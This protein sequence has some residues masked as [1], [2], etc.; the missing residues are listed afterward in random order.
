VNLTTRPASMQDHI[1][2]TDGAEAVVAFHRKKLPV[3]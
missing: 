2:F 1:L 3:L